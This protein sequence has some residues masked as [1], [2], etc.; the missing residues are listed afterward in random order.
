MNLFRSFREI[1]IAKLDEMAADGALPAGLDSARV[2]VELPRDPSHG[3]ITTNAAMVLAK[4]AGQ[5]PR[6][7]ATALSERLTALDDVE[8]AEVAGPGFVNLRLSPAFWRASLV[9]LLETG[10]AYGRSTIGAGAKV[11]VE[12]VSTNPT[13]PL[14]AGHGRGAVIGDALA[15]LLEAASYDVTREYY[16]NDAGAQVDALA[17]SVHFRYREALGAAV[18]EMPEGLY[19]GDYLIPAAEALAEREGPKWLEAPEADWLAPVRAYAVEAMMDIIRDDLRAIGI[20]YDVFTSERALV[21]AGAVDA[22]L[23]N[24]E[25][26]G[27]IYTGTLEPP[28]G[29]TP[30]DWE[31]REQTL[32]RA[33]DFGDEVDRPL[34]KSDG[35]WTYFATDIAYHNDKFARGFADMIDV[36]GADHGGYVKRMKAA[37]EAITEGKGTLDVKLCQMVNLTERGQPVRMS[38]RAG[39]FV[40]LRDVIDQVGKDVFRFI[41]LTRKNDAQLD[42][43]FAKVTEQS[44][45]NP[46]FYVQYAHAR[47]C[48]VFRNVAEALPDLDTGDKALR[49][50]TLEHLADAGEYDLIK[51][52]AGWPAVVEGAALAH[53]PHR[54]AY[55]MYD[56]AGAFHTIW[57]RGRDEPALRFIEEAEPERTL[58]RLAL[59][60][61]IQ[62]VIAS[63]LEI[64]G[65]TPVQEMR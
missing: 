60:R 11:N 1:I 55:Y 22:A 62:I 37:V 42:F 28:K 30:D 38:K 20:E 12:Y 59:L 41:M 52:L 50:A 17:R 3:D 57:T 47:I 5:K 7:I 49:A 64:F 25:G 24:L 9:A 65:V 13:G 32:F 40:T 6:D 34:K 53:E 15:A 14:H 21:A 16:I 56:L 23:A 36:W 19:P 29:K 33:T 10:A 63:G 48:S 35:S 4:P 8:A 43:D 46:V 45:D 51:R 26:R 54:I 27:L 61:G 31:P 58:A 44:K 39:T 2:V 18:G